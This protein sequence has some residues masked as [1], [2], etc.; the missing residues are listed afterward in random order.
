MNRFTIAALAGSVLLAASLL[1]QAPAVPP[2]VTPYKPGPVPPNGD[3][4]YCIHYREVTPDFIEFLRQARINFLHWHGPFHGYTGM[5]A[6]TEL[7]KMT[8]RTRKTIDEVHAAGAACILYIG[9]CFSYGDKD[10]RTIL[11]DFY[12]KRW[13]EYT[14]YFGPKPG[15]LLE[16]AQCDAKGTPRPYSYGGQDGYHLC[17]NS[18]G[19][20]QYTKGLIRM[21]CEAGG[22]GSFYDGPYVSQGNCYCKWCRERFRTW[23]KETYTPDELRQH[24]DV[25]DP[26]TAEPPLDSK[27]RLWLAWRKFGTWSLLDF[28]KDTKA[29]ARTLNPNYIMTANYCMWS[30]E[31][32]GPQVGSAENIELW[33]QAIDVIFDE[34]KYGAGPHM[35]QGVKNSNSLD[36]RYLLAAAH[37]KPV[38]LLKT[39]PDGNVPDARPNLTRLAIAEGAAQGATWQFHYIQPPASA[40]AIEYDAF[41][42]E[43][44]SVLTRARPWSPVAVW[45]SLQQAY[46]GLTSYPPGVSRFLADQHIPHTF[47]I[48]E[49]I[50]KGIA[51]PCE[52]LILPQV[53]MISDAQ[54]AMLLK[55]VENGGGLILLG[56]CG[57]HDAW[58]Q[59]RAESALRRAA[60][61]EVDWPKTPQRRESGNGR[62]ACL[63]AVSLPGSA[64]AGLSPAQEAGLAALPELIEW[65][66]GHGLPASVGADS[67]IE[68]TTAFD[69]A[70]TMLVQLVNYNV[71][72]NG[73]V[74]PAVNIPVKVRLPPCTAVDNAYLLSPDDGTKKAL[75]P[76]VFRAGKAA[77]MPPCWML[78]PGSDACANIEVP[79]LEIYDLVELQ[80]KTVAAL[81]ANLPRIVVARTGEAA[82][83]GQVTLALSLSRP[84]EARWAVEAPPEWQVKLTPG[85]NGAATCVVG[86]PATAH[87]YNHSLVVSAVLS[88]NHK[89]TDHVWVDVAAPLHV[90]LRAPPHADA[91]SGQ[92]RFDAVL[93]NRLAKPLTAQF[94]V[95]A[96]DGWTADTAPRQVELPA[97]EAQSVTFWLR[98]P[99]APKPG[100]YE[101]SVDV[102]AGA[103]GSA[104]AAAGFAVLAD[105]QALRCPRATEPPKLDGKLDDKCWTGEPAVKQF[106]RNDGKGPAKQQTRAWLAYDDKKLYV[107]ME[108]IEGE[109]GTIIALVTNDG[110]EVWRDDSVEVF[111]DQAHTHQN[112]AHY[113]ANVLGRR[114]PASGWDAVAV[115]TDVG[116][117]IEMAL[118]LGSVA[119]KPG[120]MIGL[121]LCRTRPARPQNEP[122]FSSWVFTGSSFHQPAKFGHLVFGE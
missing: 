102:A 122:E 69:G 97:S 41:L 54:I 108:C 90:E 23:L 65:A 20:R 84:A 93:H 48:D 17:V 78:A 10:K 27:G 86:V 18:P 44:A 112:A 94:S 6:R 118:P 4:R 47:L 63:P 26:A 71:D 61:V 107:A 120:D 85:E 100:V 117:T 68:V 72:L 95:T 22:D 9:P 119:P 15:D 106:L 88:D 34:A 66:G 91:L 75:L 98:A 96:P 73:R 50:E 43:H 46:A 32:F 76:V 40:A 99:A 3:L 21:I 116:W 103:A 39:A 67:S 74:K 25:T 59:V 83:G 56:P 55:F 14:D 49:D 89:L 60:G 101:V 110:G 58:G 51:P 1:A 81:P 19:V 79:R 111:L 31:P 7:E 24:F 80:L 16:M 36:Y 82:P 121:N 57:T 62:I 113:V 33:S 92:T 28:L 64:N 53:A 87:Q 52:V 8:A 70:Q 37:G 114:N 35:N 77:G 13:Q 38:A 115:R 45:A 11:F 5:P 42:A 109:P 2:A 104:R 29:Y 30:G 12:D 105:F